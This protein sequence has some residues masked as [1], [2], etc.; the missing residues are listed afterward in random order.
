MA[1]FRIFILGNNSSVQFSPGQSGPA[2]LSTT[3][4]LLELAKKQ[5]HLTGEDGSGRDVSIPYHS[6]AYIEKTN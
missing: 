4:A 3:A 2:E 1:P 6:I 5:G